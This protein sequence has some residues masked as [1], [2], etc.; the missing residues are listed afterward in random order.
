MAV[1]LLL[2]TITLI[3]AKEQNQNKRIKGQAAK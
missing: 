3:K 2:V 1:K